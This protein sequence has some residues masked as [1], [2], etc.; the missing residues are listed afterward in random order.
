MTLSDCRFTIGRAI[1]GGYVDSV[2]VEPAGLIRVEGWHAETDMPPNLLPQCRWNEELIPSSQ[3]YRTRRLDVPSEKNS[4]NHFFGFESLYILP[5]GLVKT[6]RAAITVACAG[7]SLF[8]IAADFPM[9]VPHYRHLLTTT[10]IGHRDHIYGVGPPPNYVLPEILDV[11]RSLSEP[12]LDFGCG[13]GAL[14]SALRSQGKEAV[15]LELQ[16]NPFL[17]FL[18][19]DAKQHVALYDGSLPIPFADGQFRSAIAV[20]VLEHIPGYEAIVREL[21]RVAAET[22]VLTVPDI[23]AIPL[24]FH[25]GV[26]PWHLLEATHINFFTQPALESLLRPHFARV[27]FCRIGPTVINSAKW[28]CSLIAVCQK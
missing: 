24:G 16:S 18:L 9:S 2:Q 27:D 17:T 3:F 13:S 8:S 10:D 15:G 20:E 26:I 22:V 4:A 6:G 23:S 5:E 21:S 1:P 25:Q 7:K 28:F 14:V 12:I 11:A 19:P